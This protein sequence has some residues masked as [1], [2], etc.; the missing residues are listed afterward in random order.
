MRLKS[1]LSRKNLSAAKRKW[2]TQMN[3]HQIQALRLLT[4]GYQFSVVG[5]DLLLLESGWYVTHTGLIRLAAR[6]RCRGIQCS[7]DCRILGRKKWSVCVQGNCLQ[8]SH[9]PGLCRLRRRRSFQCLVP[10]PR[11]RDARGG[12][13]CRQPRPAQGLRN[14]HLLGRGNRILCRTT[15]NVSESRR[16][17]R[18]NLRTATAVAALFAT[19]S[20]RSSASISSI[21]TS[22]SPMPPIS[23]P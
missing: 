19:G 11:R 16:S 23:A 4:Q 13:P 17:C 22:S 18:H 2:P 20:A 9:L 3:H 21:P 6:R 14:R 8:V 1:D 10:C 12:N 15:T 5:G 7:T